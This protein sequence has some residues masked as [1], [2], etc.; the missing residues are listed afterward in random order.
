ML[1]YTLIFKYTPA[2][3][4]TINV[5]IPDKEVGDINSDNSIQTTVLVVGNVYTLIIML[6]EVNVN[7]LAQF[8]LEYFEFLMIGQNLDQVPDGFQ[9][10]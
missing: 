4:K 8:S 5:I 6:K 1:P 7:I 9:F 2:E 10:L 3:N